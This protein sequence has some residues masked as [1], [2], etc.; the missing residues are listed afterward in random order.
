M[1]ECDK[2][3]KSKD[4]PPFGAAAVVVLSGGQDSVTCLFWA[5][6]N[7]EDVVAVSFD[8][9][10]RHK[11]EL[12]AAGKA[13]AIAGVPHEIIDA[14]FI[15]RLSPSALTRDDIEIAFR[16]T[17]CPRRSCR[18]GI[19]FSCRWPPPTPIRWASTTS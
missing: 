18:G 19:C 10:Q 16:K 2:C 17:G 14:K 9:G 7:F 3:K 1:C 13:A 8:Y 12:E 5:K 4:K 11:I 6:K 15:N